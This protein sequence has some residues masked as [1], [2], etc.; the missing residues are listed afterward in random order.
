MATY[1]PTVAAPPRATLQV[2]RTTGPWL[3]AFLHMWHVSAVSDTSMSTET[4]S[5][6][7]LP[8]IG[9]MLHLAI[10]AIRYISTTTQPPH[11]RTAGHQRQRQLVL[12]RPSQSTLRPDIP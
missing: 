4:E 12:S 2:S 1:G 11:R 10:R 3:Q 9:T 6:T 8:D 7:S 5:P